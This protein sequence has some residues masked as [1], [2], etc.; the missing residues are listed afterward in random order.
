V[1]DEEVR[2]LRGLDR[3]RELDMGSL[4]LL[5]MAGQRVRLQPGETMFRQ[6]TDPTSVYVLMTGEAALTR[7]DAGVVTL[8]TVF[9]PGAIVGEVGVV[10][11]EKAFASLTARTA[12]TALRFD[13]AVYTDLLQQVPGLAMATIRELSEML[14]LATRGYAE[15]KSRMPAES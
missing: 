3:F 2:L 1:F 5:A 9:G 11:G 12:V 7:A 14:M 8:L 10:L 13:G 6:G 4:K 15:L